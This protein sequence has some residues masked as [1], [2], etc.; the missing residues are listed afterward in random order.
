MTAMI[1]SIVKQ[2]GENYERCQWTSTSLFIW[3]RA[4]RIVKVLFV[5]VPIICGTLAGWD[6][7]KA[8]PQYAGLT[9]LFAFVAGL[10]PALYAALKL[11]E[12]IPDTAKLAGEYK[13]LEIAYADLQ[14]IGKHKDVAVLEKEYMAARARQEKA[15]AIAY[16][17]PQWCFWLAGR[18]IKKGHYT[19]EDVKKDQA[20]NTALPR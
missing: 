2:C 8:N 11:D 5:L 14:E 18:K 4:L 15:N 12:H 13:N 7:M 10:I 20:N 6:L 9:S 16:T 1:D 3:L 19:F 17:A